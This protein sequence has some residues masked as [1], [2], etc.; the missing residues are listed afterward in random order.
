MRLHLKRVLSVLLLIA[1]VVGAVVIV[2][3]RA[4]K[5]AEFESRRYTTTN[6]R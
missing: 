1:G 4:Q 2:A 6:E 3:D 5:A